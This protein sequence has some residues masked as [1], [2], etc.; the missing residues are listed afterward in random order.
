MRF[1][2]EGLATGIGSMPYTEAADALLMIKKYLPFIPNWPQLPQR[3][4]REHFVSQYLKPLVAAGLLIEEGGKAY[5]DTTRE[6]WTDN[7]TEFYSIYLSAEEGDQSALKYFSFPEDSAPGF[8]AFMDEMAKGTGEAVVLKGQVVGP[9]SVSFQVKDEK[10]RFAY[11]DDCLRDLVVKTLAMHAA[12]QAGELGRFGPG[13]MIFIDEPAAGVYGQSGFITVTREMIKE[14]IGAIA[15]AVH[16]AG[17]LAGVHCCD[18]MD[19]SIL[20][21]LDLDVV[22]FDSYNYF[23]SLVPFAASLKTFFGNG[24]SLAWGLVPTTHNRAVAEDGDSLLK[25]LEGQWNELSGRGIP[26]DVLFKRC[27]VTPA[28]GT[29]LLDRVQ[30]ERIF[31]LTAQISETLR[32]GKGC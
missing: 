9:L 4:S 28:C 19:W 18:A 7:L 25:I 31:Q 23:S 1:E 24:G 30:A 32:S 29:G 15:G 21:E 14:D 3:G 13:A 6:D 10:G 17:G 12:W 8:Y 11:Y 2:P 27:L 22:S 20:F 5:F 26:R 16:S